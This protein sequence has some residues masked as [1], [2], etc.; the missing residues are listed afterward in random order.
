VS[1]TKAGQYGPVEIL[2]AGGTLHTSAPVRIQTTSGALAT[3]YTDDTKSTTAANPLNTDSLGNLTF[4]ADPGAYDLIAVVGGVD[5][6]ALRIE[7][8]P[9]G[10]DM[11]HTAG[12]QTISGTK[13]FSVVYVKSDPWV[14]ARHPEY[15]GGID[16]NVSDNSGPI[17]S[18]LNAAAGRGVILGSGTINVAADLT[19]LAN[20][21]IRG[22]GVDLTTIRL[23]GTNRGFYVVN[24]PNVE[25]SDMT[26][27][28]NKA[29]TTDALATGGQSAIRFE[30]TDG[31]GCP[32]S[33]VRRVKAKN[34]HYQG[35]RFN[36][37]TTATNPLTA[38]VED[39]YCSGMGTNGVQITNASS[40][41]VTRYEATTC[42]SPG[43]HIQGG[44]HAQLAHIKS[45]D[46]TGDGSKRPH[47]VVV[48]GGAT[49]FTLDD[50]KVWNCTGPSGGD[51]CGIVIG[52]L[53][54]RW[55]LTNAIARAC[56]S[57]IAIDVSDGSAAFIDTRGVV[58]GA[59]CIDN[60]RG[61][62]FRTN[63]VDGL[64][65]S[66]VLC[67][68]NDR[69]GFFLYG[70]NITV[71]SDCH[72]NHNGQNGFAF[73]EGAN[74]DGPHYFKRA[75]TY[76]NNQDAGAYRDYTSDAL[77]NGP[78]YLDL[79]GT[80]SPE[81]VHRAGVGSRYTRTDGGA[82]TTTYL[83][84]SGTGNTG[85][86]ATFQGTADVT[87][88][89]GVDFALGSTAGTKIGTATTQK[90]GFFNAT[91]VVQ[92]S[93]YTPTNVTTDRAYDANATTTDELADVLGTLIADLKALGLI[94]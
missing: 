13:R 64:T 86:V 40:S 55:T 35:I 80:G 57:G 59:V 16:L 47:G 6:T 39:V 14:D 65:L 15:A 89:D 69:D 85:W 52:D 83:K 25:I 4:Y 21:R 23:T 37:T 30:A 10:A 84:E 28:C 67:S 44:T 54:K 22:D 66:G 72:A 45:H 88:T 11:V 50:I 51:V 17:L 46:H 9:D 53:A 90:V 49:D 5:Q 58:V 87:L 32:N 33:A 36:A 12:D 48:N 82:G 62:G 38:E 18:A 68:Y 34:G 8:V 92:P 81:T 20:T 42:G 1:Y 19:P 73:Y 94:G 91:P 60:V 93:A 26:I 41:R 75:T 2:K 63:Q 70:R 71:G 77:T 27:D 74:G 3:L 78:V 61:H 29:S 43:L 7:V 24:K 76:S 79:Q 56:D 31:T